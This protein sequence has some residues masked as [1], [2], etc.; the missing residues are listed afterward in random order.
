MTDGAGRH[1]AP[2]LDHLPCARREKDCQPIASPSCARLV[3]AKSGGFDQKQAGQDFVRFLTG[4]TTDR[5]RLLSTQTRLAAG[6][7]G[8]TRR[9]PPARVRREGQRGG[10]GDRDRHAKDRR[11]DA[12]MLAHRQMRGCESKILWPS[13]LLSLGSTVGEVDKRA[14]S[15]GFAVWEWPAL[16]LPLPITCARGEEEEEGQRLFRDLLAGTCAIGEEEAPL[17]L[18]WTTP[19]FFFWGTITMTRNVYRVRTGS[20]ERASH[21]MHKLVDC[22]LFRTRLMDRQRLGCRCRCLRLQ[23]STGTSPAWLTIISRLRNRGGC[24]CSRVTAA[25]MM[26]MGAGCTRSGCFRSADAGPAWI[27]IDTDRYLP[28]VSMQVQHLPQ[29]QDWA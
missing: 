14:D 10:H 11:W 29:E 16:G 8:R 19:D 22:W 28:G 6:P 5:R 17:L 25:R 4:S 3:T 2:Y 12:A 27:Q 21:L 13:S 23:V 24:F 1:A 26:T 20:G 7:R 9:E 18:L 15:S